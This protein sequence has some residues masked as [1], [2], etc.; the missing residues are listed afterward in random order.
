MVLCYN[1]V[2]L[3]CM[4]EW[5]AEI[6]CYVHNVYPIQLYLTAHQEANWE[7]I[8]FDRPPNVVGKNGLAFR[9][10]KSSPPFPRK[11]RPTILVYGNTMDSDILAK[12]LDYDKVTFWLG[13]FLLPRWSTRLTFLL[14]S[15]FCDTQLAG[16]CCML[17]DK[18]AQVTYIFT[19]ESTLAAAVSWALPK[20]LLFHFPV[21]KLLFTVHWQQPWIW[22]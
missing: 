4:T 17:Q 21:H 2:I 6:F 8:L 1:S 12:T 5:S 9:T 7:I 10:I 20:P 13:L 3:I 14:V 19:T 11:S 16:F 18:V 22:T 15:F